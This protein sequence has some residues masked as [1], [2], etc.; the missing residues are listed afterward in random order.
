MAAD[1]FDRLLQPEEGDRLPFVAFM[2]SLACGHVDLA[3][4]DERGIDTLLAVTAVDHDLYLMTRNT[5][6]VRASGD[7]VFN[8]WKDGSSGDFMSPRPR[9]PR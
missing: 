9:Q 3:R 1:M 7:D 6:D 5:R 8:P 2:E 4:E